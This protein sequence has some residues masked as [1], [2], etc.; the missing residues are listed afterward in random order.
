MS[1]TNWE[2]IDD[3]SFNGVR[4]FIRS[5]DEDYGT[6]QVRYEGMDIPII[7]KRNHDSRMEK[8]GTRMGD[9]LEKAAEIPCSVLYQWLKDD[10]VWALDDP[11][12]TKRKLNDPAWKYLKCRDI[13]I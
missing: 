2:M 10:G 5:S 3:G 12:Y 11:A 13:I 9:G 4:K 7:L 8:D 1:F 6:V